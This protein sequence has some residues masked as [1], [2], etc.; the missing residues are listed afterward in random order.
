MAFF[1]P[2]YKPPVQKNSKKAIKQK[3]KARV[4]LT[5]K[6][7][8]RWAREHWI[9]HHGQ[10]ATPEK[11]KSATSDG[12]SAP[13]AKIVRRAL[14]TWTVAKAA[15][16]DSSSDGEAVSWAASAPSL[17]SSSSGTAT[18]SRPDLSEESSTEWAVTASRPNLSDNWSTPAPRPDLSN[19]SSCTTRISNVSNGETVLLTPMSRTDMTDDEFPL[20]NSGSTDNLNETINC[21]SPIPKTYDTHSRWTPDR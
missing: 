6:E 13:T 2:G 21:M 20:V 16:F 4:I 7:R 8:R 15:V 11:A 5:D 1:R 17:D 18:T 19:W 9:E 3:R 10:E 14:P 12:N